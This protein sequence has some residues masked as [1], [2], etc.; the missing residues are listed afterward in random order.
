MI[1]RSRYRVQIDMIRN[2]GTYKSVTLPAISDFYIESLRYQQNYLS[3]S[4][5]CILVLFGD[6]VRFDKYEFQSGDIIRVF[7]DNVK[8]Y[9]G[10]ILDVVYD[11]YAGDNKTTLTLRADT[12]LSQFERQNLI[13]SGTD[14]QTLS[15]DGTPIINTDFFS[16]EVS[17]STLMSFLMNNSIY[18]TFN[19]ISELNNEDKVTV[20]YN[21]PLVNADSK[22]YYYASAQSTKAQIL[23][24]ALAFYQ[25]IV[26]QDSEGNIRIDAPSVNRSN[27][28]D[29]QLGSPYLLAASRSE[30]TVRVSNNT[31]Y[32]FIFTG[33]FPTV[34]P[35]AKQ[36]PVAQAIPDAKYFPR[37]A[38]L[39][40]SKDYSQVSLSVSSLQGP[41][42]TDPLLA[43]VL[44]L[45]SKSPSG[46]KSTELV[47]YSDINSAAKLLATGALANQ[48]TNAE[49]LT[50]RIIDANVFVRSPV[51]SVVSY[52]GKSFYC[53]SVAYTYMT[54]ISEIELMC[55]P[56]YSITGYWDESKG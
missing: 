29:F 3:F 5:P 53:V 17:L 11:Y 45:I 21:S 10:Y 31:V 51:N 26:Y 14:V 38:Y 2:D 23:L 30:S 36:A 50:L 9:T 44:T 27:G 4:A 34:L 22:I 13:Q 49:S 37:A 32:S 25:A 48:L 39:N 42:I 20:K 43:E 15:P 40:S 52:N 47:K 56:L 12:L 24:Q 7:K 55:V 1:N 6:A 18:H 41:I 33:F 16:N 35:P 8:N 19:K 54:G 28:Y 46:V